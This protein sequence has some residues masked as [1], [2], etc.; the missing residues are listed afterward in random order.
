MFL[1][2]RIGEKDSNLS[3]ED[4]MIARFTAERVKGSGKTSIFNIGDDYDLTHGGENL[5]EID[6]FGN[7]NSDNDEDEETLL[8]KEFVDQAHFGG[9]MTKADDDFK[10]GKSNSRKDIIENLIRESKKNFHAHCICRTQDFFEMGS[11]LS[12][13]FICNFSFKHIKFSILLLISPSYSFP[14]LLL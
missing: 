12:F 4:R 2:K 6:K 14:V 8:G 13:I 9:F 3:A 10:A 5:S 1:D 11:K 7:P